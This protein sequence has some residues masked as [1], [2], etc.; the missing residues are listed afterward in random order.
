M[1]KRQSRRRRSLRTAPRAANP[2]LQRIRARDTLP[3]DYAHIRADLK[4]IAM[5][6]SALILALVLLSFL[7]H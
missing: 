1:S 2:T 3:S 6:G 4:R 5:L 7:I